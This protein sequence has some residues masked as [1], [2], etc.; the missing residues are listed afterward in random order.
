M[1]VKRECEQSI[2]DCPTAGKPPEPICRYQLSTFSNQ[3]QTKKAFMS[4]YAEL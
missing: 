2:D 1:V 4:G 3:Q